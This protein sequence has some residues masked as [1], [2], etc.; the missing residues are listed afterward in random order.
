MMMDAL[1]YGNGGA[2]C[3]SCRGIGIQEVKLGGDF[4]E[5]IADGAV[6]TSG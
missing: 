4:R 6:Q 3:L 5:F 2:Q 1:I